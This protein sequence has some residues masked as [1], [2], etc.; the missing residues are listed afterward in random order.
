M[1]FFRQ[2]SCA[3]LLLMASS[4]AFFNSRT[5]DLSIGSNPSGA[6]IFIE[7]RSYGRTPATINIEPKEYL[8][9]LTKE[10]YGST[11]FKT[12]IWYGTV[13]TDVNGNR[14]GDGTRCILDMLTVLFSFNSWNASKC[15]DFKQKQYFL[16]IPH[17]GN[18]GAV[19]GGSMMG[20]GNNPA[21]MI[22]YYYNQDAINGA[23]QGFAAP[24]SQNHNGN[25]QQGH[26]HPAQQ[27]QMGGQMEDP[28]AGFP[29]G[30]QNQ[31]P[32]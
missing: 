32:R 12:D 6:N 8:V 31:Y 15:G 17:Y 29:Q 4:C 13:R 22:N 19:A 27:G 18:S 30:M 16:T 11:S 9:T 21:E 7:G 2:F 5:V 23:A 1:K 28:M 20:I 24:T 3:A 14:T 10:G 25:G 26:G